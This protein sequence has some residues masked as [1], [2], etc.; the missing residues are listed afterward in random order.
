MPIPA[1][2][3]IYHIVHLDRLASIIAADGLLCDAQIAA[4]STLG[5]TIGMSGIKQRRLTE[6][7]LTSHPSLFVGQC[8]PFYFCP[9]SIMLYLIH[10]RNHELTYKGGQEPILHLQVDLYQAAAWANQSTVTIKPEWYY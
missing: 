6:L 7:K 1:N 3:K 9:R 2:S 5:T 4:Q 8:V 10:Q